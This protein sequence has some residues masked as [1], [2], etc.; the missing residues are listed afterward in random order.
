M[1]KPIQK[2]GLALLL[3]AVSLPAWNFEARAQRDPN[4]TYQ[5]QDYLCYEKHDLHFYQNYRWFA[6]EMPLKVYIPPVNK[7]WGAKNLAMYTPLVQQAFLN[8]S[9]AVPKLRFQWVNNPKQA[10]IQVLWQEKYPESEVTWGRAA[11][12]T[13]YLDKKTKKIR[14]KSTLFL[15]IKAQD[16]TAMAPGEALFSEDEL[17]AIATHEVGHALGLGHSGHAEDLMYHAMYARFDGSWEI[18]ERDRASLRRLYDL[19]EDLEISPC[20]G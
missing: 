5:G 7:A 13:P 18:T 2:C 12:P 9:K 8:W 17:L 3:L 1:S 19:P 20:N 6:A 10:Q 11:Y 16:G 15:A 4:Q 14:H